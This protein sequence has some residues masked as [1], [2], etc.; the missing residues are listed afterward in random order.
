MYSTP[1]HL[2][3]LLPNTDLLIGAVLVPGSEAPKLVTRRMLRLMPRGSV[4][5]DVAVD[6]G[7]CGETTR[8]TTHE[9]PV[10]VEEGVVHY[11]VANMPGAY[12]RT[13]TEALANATR[14]AV[15]T[16][17][18]LGVAAACRQDPEL[19]DAVQCAEGKLTCQAVADSLH[20]PF[21]PIRDVLSP[22]T[23]S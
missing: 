12:A 13:S 10:Y 8:P 3:K 15:L 22:E 5:V 11:C 9:D 17:A 1:Q 18:D 21:T 2:E 23:E 6:Q 20:L 14:E 16:L 19:W 7:G 4:F